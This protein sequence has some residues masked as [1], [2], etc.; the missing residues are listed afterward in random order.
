[1]HRLS[2]IRTFGH[3]VSQA[4]G[5]RPKFTPAWP[6][7]SNCDV[8]EIRDQFQSPL[9][10]KLSVELRL[11]IYELVLGDPERFLHLCLNRGEEAKENRK[12]AHW[13]C[14]EMDSPFPTWQH[15]CFG[16]HP[17]IDGEAHYDH[18]Y[19]PPRR[20]ITVTEDRLIEILLCCRRMYVAIYTIQHSS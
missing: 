1:M 12:V 11:I 9:F 5:L 19:N 18:M 8:P 3:K 14:D 17:L 6:L 2:G 15:W 7:Q 4:V 20:K 10:G 13:R 16:D